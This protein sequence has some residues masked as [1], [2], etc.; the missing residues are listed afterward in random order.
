MLTSEGHVAPHHYLFANSVLLACSWA[1]CLSPPT[2]W[3]SRRQPIDSLSEFLHIFLTLNFFEFSELGFLRPK[4]LY[5]FPLLFYYRSLGKR[6][7]SLWFSHL[8]L[9]LCHMFML[10]LHFFLQFVVDYLLIL[11][12]Q[13]KFHANWLN[14]MYIVSFCR[15]WI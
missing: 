11:I 12:M 7:W 13:L 2:H 8:I 14:L 5:Q 6:Q 10:N 3:I 1:L 9:N 15:V 4:T